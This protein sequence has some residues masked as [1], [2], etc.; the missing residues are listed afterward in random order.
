MPDKG[1]DFTQQWFCTFG[2]MD[3]WKQ[4]PQPTLKSIERIELLQPQRFVLANGT[5]VCV[6]T[7]STLPVVKLEIILEAGTWHEPAPGIA[8]AAARMLTDGTTHRNQQQIAESI[9]FFG[10]TLHTEAHADFSMVVLYTLK[11]HFAHLLPLVAELIH[12]A[13]YPDKELTTYVKNNKQILRIHLQKVD[14]IALR[15]FLQSMFGAHHAYGH[16]VTEQDLDR[17]SSERLRLFHRR[18]Y[19]QGPLR[20]MLAGNIDD[21]EIRLVESY[22]GQQM[23][24]PVAECTQMPDTWPAKRIVERIAKPDAVQ[25]AIYIGIPVVNHRHEDFPGLLV[26]NTI[27]GG[28]FGSRLMQNLREAN[29]Y[30][31][32]IHSSVHSLRHAAYWCASTEV[33]N[34]VLSA[35]VEQ[36]YKEV[37]RLRHEPVGH[38]E[39]TQVRNYMTGMM[40][41]D[42]DGPLNTAEVYRMLEL[43]GWSE[44]YL[45]EKLNVIKTI[46]SEQ[47][48]RLAHCYLDTASM[49]EVTA[50]LPA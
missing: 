36:I 23:R 25:T 29:G 16:A 20:I 3:W 18:H 8:R 12:E 48:L 14:F 35:A 42:L 30:C 6:V 40:L 38:D 13:T 19:V 28:Y 17:L 49:I 11:K 47:L 15:G 10:A 31:Y 39:L 2:R 4:Q 27:L 46:T 41:S 26:L 24:Q 37:E 22:F 33:G 21:T 9:E 44:S 7:G 1:Y 5:R 45:E 43:N 34:E 32:G 50:G